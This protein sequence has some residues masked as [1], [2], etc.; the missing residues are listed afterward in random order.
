MVLASLFVPPSHCLHLPGRSETHEVEV[1]TVQITMAIPNLLKRNWNH[2]F[3]DLKERYPD[4]TEN[5]FKYIQGDEERLVETVSA[6]R[7]ISLNEAQRDVREFLDGLNPRRR[8]A[9]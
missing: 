1:K 8:P 2:L 3:N 4:L 7:H 9:A 6:R 5:D